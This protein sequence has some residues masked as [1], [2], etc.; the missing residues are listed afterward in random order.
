MSRLNN[1]IGSS[2]ENHPNILDEINSISIEVPDD[3]KPYL[4]R[5]SFVVDMKPASKKEKDYISSW[6]NDGFVVLDDFIPDDL[7]DNY[8]E[9]W[10]QH[11]R[12]NHDRAGGYPMGT[13][14]M[15]VPSLMDLSTYKPLQD[16]MKLLIGDDVGVHLNLTGWKSSRRDWH[17]DGYLNPNSTHDHYLAAWIALDD[18]HE[19]SG[20]FDYVRGS[21]VL[22]IISQEKT[23][24]RLEKKERNDPNWPKYS[25][26][27]L[28]PLFENIID[29]ADLPVEKFLP[30]KG[31]VMIWHARLMH[32]GTNPVDPKLWRES[33]I[34]HLSAIN[35]RPD[36]PPAKKNSRT[37]GWYFPFNQSL[38]L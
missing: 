38:E 5:S 12:T 10:I 13:P 14:Y 2:L 29:K 7:I 23:L 8:R 6:R 1:F 30:K 17:Q 31:D 26:R 4:D 11:N 20:P 35:H 24:N 15:H 3:L 22:P 32:R 25:E 16:V 33:M 21:H 19:D 18:I 9:E 34:M 37:G 28:T 27:F 36:M